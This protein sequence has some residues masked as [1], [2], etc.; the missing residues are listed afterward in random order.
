L[1]INDGENILSNVIKIFDTDTGREL[2]S[3]NNGEEAVAFSPNGQR[4]LVFPIRLRIDK[5]VYGMSCATL[6][7]STAGKTVGTIGY[8]PLNVGAKAYSDMQIARFLGNTADVNKNEAIIKFIT[9]R[10]N[11]TR[12]EIETF[13]RNG[14]RA[15]ISETVDAE[16]GNSTINNITLIQI[17]ADLEKQGIVKDSSGKAVNGIALIKETLTNF[18]LNPTQNNYERVRGIYARYRGSTY[19][20]YSTFE[21]TINILNA[22][23]TNKLKSEVTSTNAE[24]FAKIP[25]DSS[26]KIFSPDPIS[27]ILIA[28]DGSSGV[29]RHD[30]TITNSGVWILNVLLGSESNNYISDYYLVQENRNIVLR[31]A[32]VKNTHIGGLPV[33]VVQ[34]ARLPS[35]S[36]QI[37]AFRFDSS[38]RND[39]IVYFPAIV[40]F[41]NMGLKEIIDNDWNRERNG[42]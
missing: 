33:F 41:N 29:T 20:Y 38:I 2:R 1:L 35:G 19:R 10:G 37:G 24:A 32:R 18:F 14:I 8:G 4:V 25:T 30:S 3:F 21:G 28:M 5:D 40:A 7:D 26:F 42:D 34:N 36:H 17:Y 39:G 6:L 16:F 12:A 11:A 9:D 15:L 27:Y 23:L 22:S 31:L 13:Y